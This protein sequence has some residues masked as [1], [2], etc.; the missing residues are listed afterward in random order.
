VRHGRSRGGLGRRRAGR[1]RVEGGGGRRTVG[2]GGGPHQRLPDAEQYQM[3]ST[4][5][6]TLIEEQAGKA[7]CK[8]GGPTFDYYGRGRVWAGGL[9]V[10]KGMGAGR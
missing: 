7:G 5:T 6:S 4:F 3:H 1:R 9:A 8:A 10:A 2:G